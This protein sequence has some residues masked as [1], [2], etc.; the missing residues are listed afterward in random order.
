MDTERERTKIYSNNKYDIFPTIFIF[1][2]IQ[3]CTI[4]HEHLSDI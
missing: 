4:K 3:V 1:E 2:K